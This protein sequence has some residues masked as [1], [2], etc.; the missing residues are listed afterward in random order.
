[1]TKRLVFWSAD[2]WRITV[3]VAVCLLLCWM[4]IVWLCPRTVA[5]LALEREEY[6]GRAQVASICSLCAHYVTRAQAGELPPQ[7]ARTRFLQ[8][9]R[10][11]RYGAD[12]GNTYFVLDGDGRL[13][14]SSALSAGHLPEEAF[15]RIARQAM[16]ADQVSVVRSDGRP[17]EASAPG[18]SLVCV[19]RFDA[20]NLTIGTAIPLA[21]FSRQS[22]RVQTILYILLGSV[23]GAVLVIVW[24]A[25]LHASRADRKRAA[26]EVALRDSEERYRGYIRDATSIIVRIDPQGRILFA[27]EY[28][29]VFFGYTDDELRGRQVVGTLIPD[30]GQD[31]VDG[32]A[33]MRRLLAN[34]EQFLRNEN[35]NICRNGRRVWI[36][37]TNHPVYSQQHELVEIQCIGQD[38]T[39]LKQARIDLEESLF[40]H[41]Q[42]IDAV[43]VPIFYK[44]TG[45]RYL[46]CN[47]AFEDL[48]GI[49]RHDLMRKHVADVAPD[50]LA[51]VYAAKDAE[52][53]AGHEIQ[54]YESQVRCAAGERRPV[55]FSKALFRRRNGSVGGL[56]GSIFDL[57]ERVRAED[58]RRRSEARYRQLFENLGDGL[59]VTDLDGRLVDCNPTLCTL[60]GYGRE[61]LVG[62][63]IT[64]ITPAR[65]HAWEQVEV[66]EK[67][68]HTRGCAELYEKEYCRRDG[69]VLPVEI[70]AFMRPERGGMCALVRDISAQKRADEEK[71]RL[72]AVIEQCE[73]F[74]TVLDRAGRI[75]YQNPAF[76]K[77]FG[78]AAAQ[79]LGRNPFTE[80]P[81]GKDSAYYRGIWQRLQQGEAW[82]GQTVNTGSDGAPIECAAIAL[83]IRNDDGQITNYV[84]IS[85]DVTAE[86]MLRKSVEQSQKMEALGRLAGG[87]AH[88]FNNIL[89][90]VIGYAELSLE[91]EKRIDPQ[92]QRNLT[93]ILQAGHRARS[94]VSQI[95]AFSR[96][97]EVEI[98]PV[99][100]IPLIKESLKFLR[101]SLPAS[102]EIQQDLRA[103]ADTVMADPT[104][105]HQVLMNLCTNA[106]HAM[107]DDGGVLR[108]ALHNVAGAGNQSRLPP[109]SYLQL[110]VSDTGA[111]I[112]E[113]IID[114]IFDPYFTTKEQ[115]EGTGLGLSVL[116]GIVTNCHGD[117]QVESR[118][119]AGA[120]FTIYLPVCEAEMA[121]ELTPAM[122]PPGGDER[123]LVVE[124]E[125]VLSD[126]L[127]RLL[128][129]LGYRITACTDPAESIARFTRQ[130]GDF[131]LVITDKTMPRMNGFAVAREI[132]RV[133]QDIPIIIC[134]GN[135]EPDDEQ[136]MQE[137]G[138]AALV[139]KPIVR[140][141][142]ASVIRRVLDAGAGA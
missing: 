87:V 138:V 81:A 33:Q 86:Q 104:Q 37:W 25:L 53:L 74:I 127:H 4:V 91:S 9:V 75:I 123:I 40:F 2:F 105:L 63:Y 107:R 23:T 134:T 113:D 125:A 96:K 13:L 85:R 30:R 72:V 38:M 108:I 132:R 46:G 89:S 78:S 80:L 126:V 19:R 141:Q 43:P 35:E 139:A 48:L 103:E 57:S 109:G 100:L 95:L 137:S 82:R 39:A 29:Q 3:P 20:W 131:D 122:T 41:Q 94:L 16:A 47:R 118:P 88:D 83:P 61:E 28:A 44:D 49:D 11:M 14:A 140:R 65:W 110:T 62:K 5:R 97:A 135:Q 24:L 52:M 32:A 26:S 114:R 119:D 102:I 6:M 117:V 79:G 45:G 15:V 142:L 56:V 124:D 7:E 60:L 1:M 18:S 133:R 71:T 68:L 84:T 93:Q 128:S 31:G 77:K 12:G 76:E 121:G 67:Q 92:Q 42:L 54:T 50:D 101:A 111:G 36:S 10:A 106:L 129:R 116:H 34:P 115:G 8:R 112:A 90:V 27:N 51:A 55:V 136:R 120:T 98:R 70:R 73:E 22:K 69:T 58:N 21:N 66:I 99:R 17:G 64:D 130:P 59:V